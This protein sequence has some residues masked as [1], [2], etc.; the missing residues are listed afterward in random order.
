MDLIGINKYNYVMFVVQQSIKLF[1][2]NIILGFS[3]WMKS[4]NNWE[5]FI[6]N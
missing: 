2:Y 6:N 5:D 4:A 3:K 1:F